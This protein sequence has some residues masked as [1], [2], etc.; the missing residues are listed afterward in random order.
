M[1]QSALI[2][3]FLAGLLG[4]LHCIAMCGGYVG[5]LAAG[6][7]VVAQQHFGDALPFRARQP[8]RDDGVRLRQHLVDYQRPTA[9]Q[10]GNRR[11]SRLLGGSKR[12][13]V[14]VR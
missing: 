11:N 12:L 2:A 3:A 6:R 14:G 9:N 10:H 1:A 4:G 8:R 5:V 13:Q 7:L